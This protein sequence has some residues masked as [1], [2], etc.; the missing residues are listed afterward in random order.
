MKR[1]ALFLLAL[2]VVTVVLAGCAEPRTT[3]DG[4]RC[5]SDGLCFLSTKAVC[6]MTTYYEGGGIRS[7]SI[8][9]PVPP[10]AHGPL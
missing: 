7:V 1:I 10:A 4:S 5:Y 3:S 2:A 8:P 9:C 6:S